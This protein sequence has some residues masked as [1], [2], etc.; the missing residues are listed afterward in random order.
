LNWFKSYL[1]DRS[2]QTYGTGLYSNPG[3]VYIGV[4]QG[5]VI[6]LTLYQ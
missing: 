2:Q 5:S 1:K 4:P 6:G 3:H